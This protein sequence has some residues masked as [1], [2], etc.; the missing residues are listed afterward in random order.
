MRKSNSQPTSRK[1]SRRERKRKAVGREDSP[2]ELV[3][4]VALIPA[5]PRTKN[6]FVGGGAHAAFLALV[7]LRDPQRAQ[8]LH[9]ERGPKPFTVSSFLRNPSAL[10]ERREEQPR[11]RLIRFTCLQASLSEL[12]KE[13]ITSGQAAHLVLDD[14]SFPVLAWY[15]ES[16]QHPW[17]AVSTYQ[18]LAGRWFLGKVEPPHKIV[19]HFVSPTTFRSTGRNLPFPLPGL[20]FGGLLERWNAFAPIRLSM[21]VHRFAEEAL[22]VSRYNLKTHMVP[23]A[24]G[25]QVGFTGLCEYTALEGDPYGLVG[26]NILADFAFFAGVGAKTT[27]G[28][29]QCRRVE[30]WV[31]P[32]PRG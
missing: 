2:T 8:L 13:A 26:V 14:V 28:L 3:S 5:E 24:G 21:E 1:P 19:L 32:S 15:V 17:A 16:G 27:M 4:A 25:R 6:P 12:L 7:A 31:A 23:L 9:D 18:E 29:G 10:L 22:A 11:E 20:V 30:A